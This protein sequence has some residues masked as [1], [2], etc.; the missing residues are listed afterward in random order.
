MVIKNHTQLKTKIGEEKTGVLPQITHIH[1]FVW[2]MPAAARPL[3][4]AIGWIAGLSF[5]FWV[6]KIGG[7]PKI[8][9]GRHGKCFGECGMGM[10]GAGELVCGRAAFDCQ[11]GLGD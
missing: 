1:C 11:N 9:F 10:D 6:V 2:R 5:A 7:Q 4:N 8:H 3:I